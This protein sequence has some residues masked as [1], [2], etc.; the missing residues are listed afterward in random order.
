[1]QT[2]VLRIDPANPDPSVIKAAADLIRRGEVVAF[3]TETVYGLGADALNPSAVLKIFE[4]KA[5]PANNPV[6]AHVATI[7]QARE[8]V[9]EWPSF[10]Q[11]IADAF[12]PGPLTMVLPK[13]RIVP[14]V[15]TAGSG[16]VAIRFPA[17]PI[18]R[19]LVQEAGT[20]IAAPSANLSNCTSP[21]TAAHVLKGLNGK[22]PM[23]LDSEER[24]AAGVESTVI[25]IT[26]DSYVILRPGPVTSTMLAA[27]L[28]KFA[29]PSFSQSNPEADRNV[30][31]SPGMHPRHY[32]PAARLVLFS[33]QIPFDQLHSEMTPPKRMALVVQ[34]DFELP[35]DT[36]LSEISL[37]RMPESSAEYAADLYA[38]MHL[39]DD[40]GIEL[41]FWQ[42]PPDEPQWAAIRD[43]LVRAAA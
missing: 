20:P 12:W 17:H 35:R 8:L 9:T 19:L 39:L 43:R 37:V 16:T 15:V 10:A 7:E 41:I 40:S 42:L 23:V 30:A 21:T 29:A 32:S 5:R 25:K 38:R 26:T 28:G 13:S 14:D 36:T 31:E 27:A 3:P 34:D 24:L 33:D 18:A 6:I 1:M 22:I 4:S 2:I 11:K